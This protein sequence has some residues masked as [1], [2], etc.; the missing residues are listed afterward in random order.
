MFQ[1]RPKIWLSLAANK[2]MNNIDTMLSVLEDYE[3]WEADIDCFIYIDF[4]SNNICGELQN[5]LDKFEN[6]SC[7]AVVASHIF[8]EWA[9]TWAHKFDLI[10]AVKEAKY[11]YYIYAENDMHLTWQNFLYWAE[12]KPLLATTGF[13]PGFCRY[14]KIHGHKV[15]FDNY[16]Q[17]D[18]RKDTLNLQNG[19]SFTMSKIAI[20]HPDVDCFV[21]L[22]NPY[23]GAMILDQEDAVTYI[24]SKSINPDFCRGLT[25]SRYWPLADCSS[26]G[27]AFEDIPH[28]AEHRRVVPLKIDDGNPAIPD[29]GLVWHHDTKYSKLIINSDKKLITCDRMFV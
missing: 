15:P 20:S 2:P 21:T 9:L 18:L 19:Q 13:H 12:F 6:L 3:A 11:D 25:G 17:G 8:K 7:H 24:Y 27:L 28:G 23:Y 10:D 4:E 29:F 16:Y 26:M 1:K 5:I 14:E 22:V